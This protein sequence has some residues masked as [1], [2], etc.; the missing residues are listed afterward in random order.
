MKADPDS[1][2]LKQQEPNQSCLLSLRDFILNFAPDIQETIKYGMP[3][4]V[5][6]RKPFCYLWKDK[7]SG[8]PYILIVEGNKIE[9]SLLIQGGRKRMKICP[10]NPYYDLPIKSINEILKMA[11]KFY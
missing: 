7:K 6:G 3:C 10:I 9:H 1:F 2:Y 8:F 4:F 11:L 5:V